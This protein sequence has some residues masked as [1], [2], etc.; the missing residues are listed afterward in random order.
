MSD[1]PGLPP[2]GDPPPPGGTPPPPAGGTPPPPAGGTPPPPAGGAPPPPAGGAPPPPAGG[3]PPPPAGGAAPP[4]GGTGAAGL[5][6]YDPNGPYSVA[7][8][9][10]YGW[11]K[12]QQNVGVIIIA[13]LALLVGSV[14]LGIVWQF[15]V[16]RTLFTTA[17]FSEIALIGGFIGSAASTFLFS[18]LM[19]VVQAQVTRA[20]LAITDGRQITTQTFLATE[21]L[22]QVIIGAI[23]IGI[24][25]FIGTI[26]CVIPA[27]L[28]G[29][30]T[31]FFV[32]FA[33]DK[34]L[35]AID[36]IKAS[37]SLISANIAT[38]VVLF[39][40]V[41]IAYAIGAALCGVGLLVAIPVAIFAQAYTYRRLQGEPVAA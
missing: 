32:H 37:V 17:E 12:F 19:I 4:P 36:A 35:S 29:F 33:V 27:I 6:A 11:A 15:L 39:I 24:A 16:V 18:A 3:T 21:G 8:A 38:M 10:N 28:V 25:S 9:F 7:N 1:G 40:A 41:A 5:P 23:L 34:Q 20:A 2:S 13:M 26:L 22:P 30:F 31:Q 14:I